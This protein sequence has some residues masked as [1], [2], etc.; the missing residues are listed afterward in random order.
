MPV[1][2]HA[3]SMSLQGLWQLE[4]TRKTTIKVQNMLLL[5]WTSSFFLSAEAV[6]LLFNYLNLISLHWTCYMIMNLNLNLTVWGCCVTV[7]WYSTSQSACRTHQRASVLKLVELSGSGVLCQWITGCSAVGPMALTELPK[8]CV[9]A[10][11]H[12]ANVLE[13]ALGCRLCF[14]HSFLGYLACF[15]IQLSVSLQDK[16]DV[17][18]PYLIA[19]S[20]SIPAIHSE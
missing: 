19:R 6:W 13:S 9:Q 15:E 11:L 16:D 18:D 14:S 12:G 1:P 10:S 8:P 4:Q 17:F 2:G 3:C 7:E 5:A 20:P